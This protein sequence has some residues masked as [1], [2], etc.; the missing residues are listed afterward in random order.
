M[1]PGLTKL[2]LST[3][4]TGAPG[5][6][7]SSCKWWPV[8][9]GLF[10][11]HLELKSAM[12]D[13]NDDGL[14]RVA[15]KLIQPVIRVVADPLKHSP[16]GPYPH[17]LEGKV[18]STAMR[19]WYEGKEPFQYLWNIVKFGDRNFIQMSQ[20]AGSDGLLELNNYSAFP[21]YNEAK[22]ITDPPYPENLM[23]EADKATQKV[24]KAILGQPSRETNTPTELP[25]ITF[26]DQIYAIMTTSVLK[27][28]TRC[29]TCIG[30]APMQKNLSNQ[31]EVFQE[32]AATCPFHGSN[33]HSV[34]GLEA[35]KQEARK[36]QR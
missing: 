8:S 10:D 30:I 6:V 13:D 23:T 33:V 25:R 1:Y 15:A 3:T 32:L 11:I 28:C 22:Y 36:R 29:I 16:D 21:N 27:G 19:L 26:P 35:M 20:Y 7:R 5:D 14:D 24:V 34:A 2:P 31:H 18:L 9:D 12:P 4:A 17:G